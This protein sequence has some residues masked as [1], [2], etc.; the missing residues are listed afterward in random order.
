[1]NADLD[2]LSV[3]CPTCGGSGEVPYGFKHR[4]C[5]RCGG[6]KTV[7]ESPDE[8]AARLVALVEQARR[9]RDIFIGMFRAGESCDYCPAQLAC[10]MAPKKSC[11]ELLLDH[12]ARAVAGKESS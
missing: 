11:R 8:Y 9:E 6:S 1:M 7:P 4:T 2:R 5:A 10:R 12:A 3:P